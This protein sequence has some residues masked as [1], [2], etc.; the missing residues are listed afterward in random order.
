MPMKK[1]ISETLL[2]CITFNFKTHFFHSHLLSTNNEFL[3][4]K[5]PGPVPRKIFN[6]RCLETP[7]K[8]FKT[9]LLDV[10]LCLRKLGEALIMSNNRGLRLHPRQVKL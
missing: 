3:P 6:F 7:A 5:I 4:G 2:Q 10:I 8:N 9:F 1:N